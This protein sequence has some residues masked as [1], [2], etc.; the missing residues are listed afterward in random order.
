[1]FRRPQQPPT[2]F[3][4]RLPDEILT[5]IFEIFAPSTGYSHSMEYRESLDLHVVSQRWQRVSEPILYRKIDLGFSHWREYHRIRQL[6][7]TL[8]QHPRLAGHIRTVVMFAHQPGRH[9][10]PV[11]VQI[12]SCCHS[13]W[14]IYLNLEYS[15]LH[16]P[17]VRALGDLP[18]LKKAGLGGQMGGPS[19]QMVFTYFN[20]PS[21][22]ELNL[23]RYGVSTDDSP[24]TAWRRVGFSSALTQAVSNIRHRNLTTL[25]LSDPDTT[26][27]VT[28]TLMQLSDRLT[29]FSLTFMGGDHTPSALQRIL[30]IHCQSLQHITL[31]P[32]GGVYWQDR[33]FHTVGIPDFTAFP[34]LRTLSLSDM[35]LFHETPSMASTKLSAPQ[36]R[37]LEINFNTEDQISESPL[38]FGKEHMRWIVDFVA[39]HAA[40]TRALEDIHIQFDPYNWWSPD[41]TCDRTWPWTYMEQA[42]NEL[43][44][45]NVQLTH[46]TPTWTKQEWEELFQK[47]D[48]NS[49]DAT[50]ESI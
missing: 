6:A 14:E 24:G 18:N 22:R 42:R 11:L 39:H 45:W 35:N 13:A 44:G 3:I 2:C 15:N 31:G 12:I 49:D 36:L 29:T 41:T 25:N 30:D 16:W 19:L 46:S 21:L 37:C 38:D 23:K 5:A 32:L 28:E 7:R 50:Q 4:S 40:N 26:P 34:H 20:M 10:V 27:A 43:S 1:M 8:R 9:N 47:L 17:I 48:A 33:V